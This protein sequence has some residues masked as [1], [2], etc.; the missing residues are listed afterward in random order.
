MDTN[1]LNKK[2][3]EVVNLSASIAA[4]CLPCTK[5][6]VKKCKK[7]GL[8]DKEI[9]YIINKIEITCNRATSAM[10][11]KASDGDLNILEESLN[12]DINIDNNTE[13]LIGITVSY[14]MNNTFLFRSYSSQSAVINDAPHKIPEIIKISK[15]IAVKA[16]IHMELLTEEI[17]GADTSLPDSDCS[18]GCHC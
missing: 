12:K 10:V 8:T 1:Y 4:G 18:S 17:I 14:I 7:A 13:A 11:K 6:H 16:R 5:F 9:E 15:P 2:E 3:K